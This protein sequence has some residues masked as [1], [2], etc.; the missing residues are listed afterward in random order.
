[1]CI[2]DSLTPSLPLGCVVRAGSASDLAPP[3]SPTTGVGAAGRD[4][5]TLGNPDDATV[6]TELMGERAL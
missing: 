4:W 1:M 2:R 6:M 5:G 3:A